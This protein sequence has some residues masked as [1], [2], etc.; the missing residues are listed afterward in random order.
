MPASCTMGT[1]SFPGGKVRRGA[2]CWPL[3]PSS[4][5]VSTPLWATTGPVTGLLYLY[6]LVSRCTDPWMSSY[7]KHEWY[8]Y[9]L[10]YEAEAQASMKRG[11]EER[12]KGR[13]GVRIKNCRKILGY[14]SSIRFVYWGKSYL[15]DLTLQ[16]GPGR[17]WSVDC[18]VCVRNITAWQFWE[19]EYTDVTD[20]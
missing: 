16:T 2:C 14:Y 5:E 18:Q 1:G 20:I 19:E 17:G 3:T 13:G 11:W 4:A 15:I 9:Q 10:F 7:V 6:R 8:F 12:R